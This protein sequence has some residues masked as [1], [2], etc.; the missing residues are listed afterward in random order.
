M[1]AKYL[2]EWCTL[3]FSPFC[4]HQSLG[5][6]LRMDCC[7]F[8]IVWSIK[9]EWEEN[10]DNKCW[11]YVRLLYVRMCVVRIWWSSILFISYITIAT[12][13]HWQNNSPQHPPQWPCATHT[14]HHHN[15]QSRTEY[16]L[17]TNNQNVCVVWPQFWLIYLFILICGYGDK[18]GFLEHICAERWIRQLQYIVGSHQMETW[19]IFVHRVQNRLQNRD[20]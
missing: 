13:R 17:L 12:E 14:S 1:N 15:A 9:S 7:R 11:F 6:L 19:L 16:D 4:Q 18:F 20:K 10:V 8:S 2:Y 5:N 3:T